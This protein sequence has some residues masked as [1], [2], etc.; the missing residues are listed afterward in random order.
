MGRPFGGLVSLRQNLGQQ[1]FIDLLSP[2]VRWNVSCAE[3]WPLFHLTQLGLVWT[4]DSQY[5]FVW[6]PCQPSTTNQFD[7]PCYTTQVKRVIWVEC[8]Q[9]IVNIHLGLWA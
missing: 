6:E 3:F 8:L 2:I 9:N 5:V 7:G 4:L 1:A